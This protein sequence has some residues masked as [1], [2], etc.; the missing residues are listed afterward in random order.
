MLD[1]MKLKSDLK[2]QNWVFT[3]IKYKNR[4]D[5]QVSRKKNPQTLQINMKTIHFNAYFYILI[6][7]FFTNNTDIFLNI[8]TNK[9]I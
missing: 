1:K 4:S 3:N 2:T 5:Y 8:F 7:I 9:L 6:Y